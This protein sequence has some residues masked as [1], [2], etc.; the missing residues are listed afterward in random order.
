MIDHWSPLPISFNTLS[1]THQDKIFTQVNPSPMIVHFVSSP[2]P[3]DPEG[4]D[5]SY[6]PWVD[7]WKNIYRQVLEKREG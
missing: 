6:S 2:K 4:A 7:D 5:Y 1:W 3:W